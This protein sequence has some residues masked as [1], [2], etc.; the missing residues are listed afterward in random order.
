MQ[1]QTRTIV[2]QF[3]LLCKHNCAHYY[4]QLGPF[5]LEVL[6][7]H[8]SLWFGCLLPLLLALMWIVYALHL[9]EVGYLDLMLL[10]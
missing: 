8:R 6:L 3:S 5:V 7:G 10:I 2:L 4:L 1:R 9:T